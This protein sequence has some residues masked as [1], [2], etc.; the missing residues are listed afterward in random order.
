MQIHIAR[1]GQ[2]FGPYPLEEVNR[3]LVAG[4]IRLTDL[5][6]YEGIPAWIS[7]AQVPGVLD[8]ASHQPPAVIA[9]PSVP[10]YAAGI[11]AGFWIRVLAYLIDAIILAVALEILRFVLPTGSARHTL[12]LYNFVALMIEIGYCAGF[13]T[14]EWQATPGQKICSLRVISAEDGGRIS[15]LR[16]IARFFALALSFMILFIGVIMVAFTERKQGL[17]DLI[18]STYVVQD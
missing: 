1:D 17:H 12:G 2:R 11:Y 18:C 13:W 7:L 14:S 5:A 16:G 10:A 15:L 8:P 6:W 9:A 3:Q 4:T